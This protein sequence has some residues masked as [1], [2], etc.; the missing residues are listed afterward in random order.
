MIRP[1]IFLLLLAALSFSQQNIREVKLLASGFKFPEGPSVDKAGN[2]FLINLGNGS[3]FKVT[4]AGQVSTFV[5]T[6]GTNQ[7]CLFD[8][9][10]NLYIC[11]NEPGRTGILKVDP[12]GKISALTLASEGRPIQ[13]TNDM[14][15]GSQGRLYFTCPNMDM[16]HPGGEINFVEP[17]G[18]TRRFASGLVFSNGITFNAD[19]TYLYVGEE[20]SARQLGTIWRFKVNPDGTADPRGKER[21]FEFSG[22]PYGF[23]GM[24][25]DVK[26]NLWIAM[27]SESE[28]W[29][30]SPEGKK[31]DSIP[32]PAKNPT[33]LVFGGPENSIAY[34]TA[35]EGNNG[36]LFAVRMPV[37]G[38]R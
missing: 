30:L 25:F 16:I 23:D 3:V 26:G 14:A 31:I 13:R 37:A 10:G 32:I 28:I 34:V 36:K 17:D 24:K 27:F 20:R 35:H 2:V 4:P 29:C 22:R 18:R 1:S 12:A 5:D 33:N 8:Q 19:K 6:G 7:S 15:W 38:A 9:E 11:H 21:F